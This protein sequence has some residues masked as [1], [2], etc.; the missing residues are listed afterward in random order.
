MPVGYILSSVWVRWGKF[1]QLS[2]IQYVGLCFFFSLPIS[3]V[4]IE[5]I[6]ILCLIIIVKSEVWTITHCLGLGHETM[7]CAVYLSIFL[8]GHYPNQCWL[9]Q[10][11]LQLINCQIDPL[12][13]T[14]KKFHFK[15][16][17]FIQLTLNVRGPSYL[18]LT[19]SI[20]WLL[21]PWLLACQDI[22]SHDIDCVEKAG[23]CLT[24]G[25]ISTTCVL[26]VWK[27]GTK[28]K[29]MFM[30]P[31]KNL[32]CKGLNAVASVCKLTAILSWSTYGNIIMIIYPAIHTH[33]NSSVY[34]KCYL[35]I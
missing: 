9:L 16:N 2:I 6:Y 18:G 31:L 12:I 19:R 28:C 22:N 24:R 17:H 3:L 33:N 23:A 34:L 35:K 27:N 30:F 11:L 32:A 10:L 5:R 15:H 20:S 13:W 21:M 25:W 29:C 8:W 26:L 14:S 7:V 4:M 1:S